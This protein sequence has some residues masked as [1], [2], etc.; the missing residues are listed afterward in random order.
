[1]DAARS[2]L[3]ELWQDTC[4]NQQ[5]YFIIYPHQENANPAIVVLIEWALM[6][7]DKDS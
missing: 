4:S 1:M 7:V 2:R 3:V 5:G 6:E